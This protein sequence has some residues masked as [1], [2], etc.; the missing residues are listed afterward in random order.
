M[1]STTVAGVNMLYA[2]GGP[3]DCLTNCSQMTGDLA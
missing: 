3:S 2:N 1:V